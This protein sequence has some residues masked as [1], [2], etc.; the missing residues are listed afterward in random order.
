MKACRH[1]FVLLLF[2]ASSVGLGAQAPAAVEFALA[3]AWAG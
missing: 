1:S 2:V 3:D